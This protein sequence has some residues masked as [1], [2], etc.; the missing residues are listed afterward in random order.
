MSKIAKFE[1]PV[2]KNMTMEEY[3]ALHPEEADVSLEDI[4]TILSEAIENVGSDALNKACADWEKLINS[5][6][7][8]ALKAFMAENG[9][10]ITE[11]R[12]EEKQ[13]EKF[14]DKKKQIEGRLMIE[15]SKELSG[16]K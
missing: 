1:K 3:F 11:T 15:R 4:D 14:F 5:D 6:T 10:P 7:D 2:D 9:S 13:V 8:T 12:F 16:R